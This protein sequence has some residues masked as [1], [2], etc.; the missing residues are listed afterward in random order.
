MP[1]ISVLM[2]CFNGAQFLKEA[3]NSVY[4]QTYLDWEVIFV[5]NCSTDDSAKIAKSYGNKVKYYKTD[6]NIPLGAARN[7]GVQFCSEY[8]AVLDTD[9]IWLPNSLSVL[10]DAIASEGFTLAYGNQY[11]IDKQGK[12]VGKITNLYTGEKGNFFPKLLMQF[13]I[14]LVATMINKKKM[15]ELGLNFDKNIFGSEEYCLFVQMAIDGKFI[16]IPDFIVKYRVHDSLT[17]KLNDKIHKERFYTLNMIEEKN[18]NIRERYPIEFNE[19]YARGSYYKAQYLMS[20]NKK[21]EAFSSLSNY[22]FTDKKYFFL[23]IMTLFPKFIWNYVQN[24]K[25]KR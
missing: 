15:L 24:A 19:A 23:A 7:F 12:N 8:I 4:A 5:D 3:L 25:Y 6:S 14:P 16:A 10:Y 17:S 13:D 22:M 2:N 9:D 11:L 18:I 21:F 1:K 20:Q